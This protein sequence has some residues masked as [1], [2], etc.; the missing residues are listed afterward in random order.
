MFE[1]TQN[2]LHTLAI[3]SLWD[4]V[5]QLILSILELGRLWYSAAEVGSNDCGFTWDV[6]ETSFSKKHLCQREFS[7]SVSVNIVW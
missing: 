3:P 5:L 2:L 7:C 6:F 4:E 1:G